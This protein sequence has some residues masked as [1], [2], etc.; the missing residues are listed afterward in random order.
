MNFNFSAGSLIVSMLVSGIG[1]IFFS[2]GRKQQN[3]FNVFIGV[4]LMAFPYFVSDVAL[5]L[6][7]AGA[8]CAAAYFV[9]SKK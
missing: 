4:L 7:I 2:H 6:G 3:G 9:N 1:Y 8:L 5:M